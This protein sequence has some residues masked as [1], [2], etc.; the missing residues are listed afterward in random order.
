M[1]AP[2]F[3]P[4]ISEIAS[5]DFKDLFRGSPMFDFMGQLFIFPRC[6]PSGLNIEPWR[7]DD[8]NI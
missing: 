8:V 5:L 6:G 3:Q 2:E 7:N 1:Y 4:L